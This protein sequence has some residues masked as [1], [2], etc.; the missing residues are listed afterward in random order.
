MENNKTKTTLKQITSANNI[1][2]GTT[3]TTKKGNCNFNKCDVVI[4]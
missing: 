3:K 1:T 4:I 2:A